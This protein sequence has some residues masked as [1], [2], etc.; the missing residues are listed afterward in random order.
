MIFNVSD[1]GYDMSGE[2][3]DRSLDGGL[4]FW[5]AYS[6]GRDKSTV[7]LSEFSVSAVDFRV[8]LI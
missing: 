7:V 1:G 6:C 8:I 4:V 2:H 5:F 3:S